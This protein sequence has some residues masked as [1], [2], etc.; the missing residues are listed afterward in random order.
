M[1]KEMSGGGPPVELPLEPEEL[2]DVEV[3][4]PPLEQAT[5]HADKKA[6]AR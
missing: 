1:P 2:L 6:R 5:A 3:A 4:L